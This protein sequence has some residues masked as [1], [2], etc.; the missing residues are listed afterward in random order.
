M[1][2]CRGVSKSWHGKSPSAQAASP[3]DASG[4]SEAQID[5]VVEDRVLSIFG[6]TD[7]YYTYVSQ[8]EPATCS[9][10]PAHFRMMLI[11]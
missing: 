6:L 11:V 1:R 9:C 5:S 10:T 3:T 7:G 4:Y 2:F 8:R